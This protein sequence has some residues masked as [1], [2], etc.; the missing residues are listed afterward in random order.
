MP[1]LLPTDQNLTRKGSNLFPTNIESPKSHDLAEMSGLPGVYMCSIGGQSFPLAFAPQMKIPTLLP[2]TEDLLGTQNLLSP[3][4]VHN[5]TS[6]TSLNDKKIVQNIKSMEAMSRKFSSPVISKESEDQG[7]QTDMS[8]YGQPM[9]AMRHSPEHAM[10]YHSDEEDETLNKASMPQL[11]THTEVV[12]SLQRPLTAMSDLIP[13]MGQII[14][15]EHSEQF[16]ELSNSISAVNPEFFNSLPL[17]TMPGQYV[18]FAHDQK[19][20]GQIDSTNM[21][22]NELIESKLQ[23]L[24][25][26]AA[27][28]PGKANKADKEKNSK[29]NA[30]RMKLLAENMSNK[31]VYTS[32]LKLPWSKR[33]RTAKTENGRRVSKQIVDQRPDVQSIATNSEPLPHTQT[34]SQPMVLVPLEQAGGATGDGVVFVPHYPDVKQEHDQVHATSAQ[35]M[36]MVYPNTTFSSANKPTRKRGRPPKV[37][38]LA[39]MLAEANKLALHGMQSAMMPTMQQPAIVLN[40]NNMV[41][42]T[43]TN[44]N[45][46]TINTTSSENTVSTTVIMP[47]VS[48]AN[49]TTTHVNP[50]VINM[51]QQHD[52]KQEKATANETAMQSSP[53][54]HDSKPHMPTTTELVHI[55]TSLVSTPPGMSATSLITTDTGAMYQEMILSSKSLVNV[56]P[57][58]RQTTAELLQSKAGN[59]DFI[60]T[61]F[62][63]GSL[64]GKAKKKKSVG[65]PGNRRRGR[66]PKKDSLDLLEGRDLCYSGN[67]N[68]LVSDLQK[69][70]HIYKHTQLLAPLPP[71][72]VVSNTNLNDLNDYNEPMLTTTGLGQESKLFDGMVDGNYDNPLVT[73]QI[74]EKSSSEIHDAWESKF[75]YSSDD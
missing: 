4:M 60:C 32:V 71:D 51:P 20:P 41:N 28:P 69:F 23:E 2:N 6:E 48:G 58:K 7:R 49:G 25:K 43:G 16:K 63:L 24:K 50:S 10:E 74:I 34:T 42:P 72:T 64:N 19:E 75:V 36:M 33:T 9:V 1:S 12:N 15:K 46:Q 55:P 65:P 40:V 44:G 21:S 17:N 70:P 37:P 56:N 68:T 27:K 22:Q 14:S 11:S 38:V 13:E 8:L 5:M 57:R 67:Q 35:P 39:R 53:S 29:K 52:I 61:S 45:I 54:Q 66:P 31:G 59:Q 73:N 3:I 47:S 18:N 26:I 30:G 62:R